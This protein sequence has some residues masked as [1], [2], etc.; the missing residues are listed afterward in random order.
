MRYIYY[1]FQSDNILTISYAGIHVLHTLQSQEKA[2]YVCEASKPPFGS[3]FKDVSS[4]L[5]D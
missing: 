3:F 2:W 1:Y 5:L 4:L